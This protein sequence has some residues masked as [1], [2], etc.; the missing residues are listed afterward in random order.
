MNNNYT[1]CMTLRLEPRLEEMITEAAYDRRVSKS[2]WIRDAIRR[3]L[4]AQ[5]NTETT[6][7]RS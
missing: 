6:G 1:H 2:D 5:R 4:A 3:G 7:V